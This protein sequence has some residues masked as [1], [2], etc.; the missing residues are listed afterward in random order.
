M[1]YNNIKIGIIGC[2]A[3]GKSIITF[4]R[5]L[6]PEVIVY[7]TDQRTLSENEEVFLKQ[8]N[9]LFVHYDQIKEFLTLSEYIFISPGCDREPFKSVEHKWI[10]EVDLFFKYTKKPVI[11]VTG[12]AGKTSTVLLLEHILKKHNV[13]VVACGNSGFPLLSAL[14]EQ[15]EIDFFIAE[16]SSFQLEYATNC[17]ADYAMITNFSDNHLDRHKTIESYKAAK[18]NIFKYQKPSQYAIVPFDMYG[19]FSDVLDHQKLILFSQDD[20]NYNITNQLS[21]I[22]SVKNWNGICTLLEAIDELPTIS[23]LEKYCKDFKNEHRIEYVGK[24]NGLVFYNDSKAT[25]PLSTL[26][27]L[28][29]FKDKPVI[30]MLGGFSK[31]VDRKHLIKQLPSNIIHI[32]CFGLEAEILGEFCKTL[33]RNY[34]EHITIDDAFNTVLELPLLEETIVLFSPAGATHTHE[35]ANYKER[36]NFF[37]SL[38]RSL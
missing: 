28:S 8:E 34:S 14:L 16:L 22:T 5:K 30:L 18:A 36:G 26:H 4:L 27:A 33:R 9:A 38:V 24:K 17:M 37:K 32:A 1:D 10:E 7:I 21:D 23:E 12:S 3:V 20:N 15:D 6:F 35:F 19:P 2:G 13:R 29:Q 11:A 31:G 25:L